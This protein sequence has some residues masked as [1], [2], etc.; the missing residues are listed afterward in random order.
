MTDPSASQHPRMRAQNHANGHVQGRGKGKARGDAQSHAPQRHTAANP[1]VVAFDILSDVLGNDAYANLLTPKVVAASGMSARDRAFATD[2]VYGTLRWMRLLD[3]I[4]CAAARR[5]ADA[6]DAPC[7]TVLRLGAYQALF[8]GV[9]DHAAVSCTVALAKRRV[10]AHAGGFVNAVMHRIVGRDRKEWESIV[11][12]RIPQS[13]AVQRLGVRYSHPDWV[14]RELDN[15]WKASGYADSA[16]DGMGIGA[17]LERDNEPPA[18]TLVARPGLITVGDLRAELPSDAHCEPGMWSPYALRVRGVAPQSVA[19][20][21]SHR[22]GV[23]D[24]GSQ[25]AALVLAAAPLEP[26]ADGSDPSG[27]SAKGAENPDARWLDMCAGPGGKTALLA[28]LAA[29]RG[30][31]VT[32]NEPSHH[33][34]QLVRENVSAVPDGIDQVSERDGA[35]FGQA[36]PGSFDRVLVD[37]PCSGLGALRRRPEA[38]WRKQAD[39]I[40]ALTEVQ[41]GLLASALRA[42]RPGG[43]V[44]YVTCSPVLDET[45]R[46]V[47][48]VLA[49]ATENADVTAVRCDARGILKH[50]V[51]DGAHIPVPE[52]SG[53]VQL[54]EQ[55]HGTDQMFISVL[56]RVR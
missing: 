1:R 56:R 46:V 17:M 21:R 50:V 28:S 3:A 19:A 5:A 15:S 43:V 27:A 2:L 37:A 47:D 20:V 49:D 22:A 55:I 48:A 25:L 26:V 34:A 13:D 53:D 12:S 10:G 33:R 18:V 32:A 16:T 42:V 11:V 35:E 31:K 40:A 44:A 39:D 7:L 45:V 54:F 23:E 4:V 29:M 30:A 41:K 6:I 52:G 14:V 24:E 36:M 38:R 51:R 9:P 8:L